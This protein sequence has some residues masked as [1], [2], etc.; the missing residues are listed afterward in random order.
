MHGDAEKIFSKHNVH[1][2]KIN[3]TSINALWNKN[4]R[5]LGSIKALIECR[6]FYNEIG[7]YDISYLSNIKFLRIII[8]KS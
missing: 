5:K 6:S 3:K 1:D 7:K 8:K 2:I 4:T